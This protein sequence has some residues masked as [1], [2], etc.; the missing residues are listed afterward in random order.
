MADSPHPAYPGGL[1]SN[2][3]GAALDV[4]VPRMT[5]SQ[6]EAWRSTVRGMVERGETTVEAINASGIGSALAVDGEV[7]DHE[8]P[9]V[10]YCPHCLGALPP[11]V[12][13]ACEECGS[14]TPAA[15]PVTIR[16]V[17]GTFTPTGPLTPPAGSAVPDEAHVRIEADA[18]VPEP[19]GWT[20]MLKSWARWPNA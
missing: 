17:Q 10:E 3:F 7:V 15:P 16:M 2:W 13:G 18:P 12:D 4:A 19:I 5:E 1:S 9:A 6:L 11:D 20:T 14:G 8:L